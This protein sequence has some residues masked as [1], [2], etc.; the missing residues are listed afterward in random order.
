M[1]ALLGPAAVPARAG[2]RFGTL[3]WTLATL[4]LLL[5]WDFSGLDR[6]AMHRVGDVNGFPWR[7]HVLTA[8]V[9]HDGGRLLGWAMVLLLVVNVWRPL[10]QGPSR[11]DRVR[12]LLVTVTCV[13][14]VPSLKWISQTSCPWDLAEFGGVAR[15]VSHWAPGGDGGPG[16]CFPS[17]HATAAFGFIGGWFVLRPHR[18]RLALLWLGGVLGLGLL[19]G[20]GQYLR[21]AHHPSHTLWSAWLCWALSALLL[22]RRAA[23]AA[24]A[25]AADRAD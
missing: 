15:Y 17:G 22:A 4:A 3:A 23:P 14:A 7:D 16:R 21:G 24:V 12:W 18:P 5:L 8:R 11:A 2:R 6:A 10:W 25:A 19:F 1:S 13:L 20:L 9:V